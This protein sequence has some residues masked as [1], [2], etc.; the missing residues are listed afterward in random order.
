[1]LFSQVDEVTAIFRSL[2][3][4]AQQLKDGV[5]VDQY[6]R[7]IN[8]EGTEKTA[9]HMKEMAMARGQAV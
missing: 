8:V 5:L 4:F 7:D 1:M 6:F 2:H 3:Q 9:E